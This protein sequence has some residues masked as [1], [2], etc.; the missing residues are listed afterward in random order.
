MKG[1]GDHNK[2][3]KKV[4]DIT[5]K[6]YHHQILNNA[7][8]NHS[9][10]NISQARKCYQYLID[11]GFEDAR[12]F[13]N[14]GM[15]LISL[16][17][18]KDA[19]LSIRKAIE[20]NPKDELAYFYLGEILKDLGKLKDAELSIRKAIGLNPNFAKAYANLGSI[21]K[22][23]G[24]LKDAELSIQKAI[25][26]NPN[27][28]KAYYSLSLIQYSDNN[29]ILK[30]QLFSKNILI[31]K[32][33]EDKVDIYFARANILHKEKR[34][35]E[36]SR[37]LE[38]ANKLKLDLKPSN[39]NLIF[40]KSKELLIQSDKENINNTASREYPESIFIV[41]M[42]R[43]GST[44]LESILS[45]NTNVNDLGEINILEESFLE[46]RKVDQELTLDELY[47]KKV[48][49][50]TK[51][52]ITT[53]KW[54]HNYKYAGII[55]LHISKAKIIHC[56]RNPLDNILS[57]YRANFQ[58]GNTYSSSLVDCARVYLDQEEIMNQYKKRF[59]S[60]IYDLN[61]DLLVSNPLKEIKSLISWLGWKWDDKYLSP[62]LNPRSVSTAS[63]I[64]VRSPINSKSIGGWKNYKEMLKPA[65][66]ILTQ[67]NKYKDIA[68]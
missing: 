49:N 22:K 55:A 9:D 61:Y 38:L 59:R 34:Y 43:S 53:N 19:E 39:P 31:K 14:Y 46:W 52:N 66:E 57:I 68:S 51:F 29:K 58:K 44:L 47:L 6:Q 21:L 54:L 64:Q 60:K 56:F 25:E 13:N 18:L 15:L 50:K 42:P 16:G 41:G 12:V 10:G 36:S 2:S 35:E 65:I 48:N 24:Q 7:L 4:G 62:H 11:N 26:L 27:F 23:I 5:T 32:S 63:N 45:M 20:L 67:T 37:Y 40:N 28:A 8:K 33:Q 17:K 30:D 1:F 3:K